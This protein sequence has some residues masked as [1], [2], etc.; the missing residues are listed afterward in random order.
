MIDWHHIRYLQALSC[1]SLQWCKQYLNIWIWPYLDRLWLLSVRHNGNLC[2]K[3]ESCIPLQHVTTEGTST[4]AQHSSPSCMFIQQCMQNCQWESNGKIQ[5]NKII[6]SD[7]GWSEHREGG[8]WWICSSDTLLWPP[9]FDFLLFSLHCKSSNVHHIDATFRTTHMNLHM[10]TID[11]T[12]YPLQHHVVDLPYDLWTTLL[13]FPFLVPF[14]LPNVSCCG[15]TDHKPLQHAVGTLPSVSLH[16]SLVLIFLII[17]IWNSCIYSKKEGSFSPELRLKF[18][19]PYHFALLHLVP[20]PISHFQLSSHY[21][22]VLNPH[23][24]SSCTPWYHTRRPS[25]APKSCPSEPHR[26]H[27]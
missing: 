14:P 3:P 11:Y 5:V 27:T 22:T 10:I 16:T 20:S 8:W 24:T 1:Y 9:I 21:H 4:D 13:Y 6:Q 19:P 23:F 7:S 2:K 25:T 15:L 12:L 17:C 18:V 26:I